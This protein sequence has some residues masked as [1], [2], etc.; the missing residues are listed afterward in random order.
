MIEVGS[1]ALKGSLKV[2]VHYYE[3]GN[4]QLTS[5]KDAEVNTPSLPSDVSIKISELRGCAVLFEK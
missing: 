4:V 3:D 2:H 1:V 5:N